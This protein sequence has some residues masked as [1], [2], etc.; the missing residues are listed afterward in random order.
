[1]NALNSKR[2][3]AIPPIIGIL[4]F[5]ALIAGSLTYFLNNG[6]SSSPVPH[7]PEN[8]L[9]TFA[10]Y[11]E[12]E[13]YVRDYSGGGYYGGVMME[14]AVKSAVDTQ[15][16]GAPTAPVS[17][18]Y[19]GTNIQ[20]EGVD[21]A[22]IVKSDGKYIYAVSGSKISVIDAYPAESANIVSTI[23]FNG[24]INEIFVNGDKLV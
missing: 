23:D 13:S 11:D 2:T 15:A 16:G 24:V 21:E 19:S 17:S 22:D 12:L 5:F 10:S 20:V 1:M 7:E 18:D 4:L 9:N 8:G 14:S 6:P 3:G